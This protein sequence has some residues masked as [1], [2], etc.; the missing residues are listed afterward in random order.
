MSKYIFERSNRTDCDG[1]FNRSR[2]L[3]S[4]A[5]KIIGH[6]NLATKRSDILQASQTVIYVVPYTGCNL[7]IDP[8]A[9]HYRAQNTQANE[10]LAF[11]AVASVV[12]YS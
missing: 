7:N 1:R 2:R 8:T 11:A 9:I 4:K 12:R 5:G 10:I 3:S 6:A